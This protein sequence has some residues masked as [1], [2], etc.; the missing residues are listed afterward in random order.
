MRLPYSRPSAHRVILGRSSSALRQG[1]A[2]A[3][4]QRADLDHG[5]VR[6]RAINFQSGSV[7]IHRPTTRP[8]SRV[9][10]RVR[11]GAR[12]GTSVSFEDAFLADHRRHVAE[13]GGLASR[14]R[15]PSAR[16]A[17]IHRLALAGSTTWTA[18]SS[19]ISASHQA[20]AGEDRDL[21]LLN[22]RSRPQRAQQPEQHQLG[23]TGVRR[24][25]ASPS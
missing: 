1:Q 7:N 3:S 17:T 21:N 6:C 20:G 22:R 18:F 8:R 16:A 14:R 5:A 25:C 13:P 9:S 12:P 15:S 11:A 10:G 19:R 4:T 24:A 2:F 23:Q